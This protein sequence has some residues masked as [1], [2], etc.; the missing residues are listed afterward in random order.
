MFKFIFT[1]NIMIIQKWITFGV[2]GLIAICG[3]AKAQDHRY[4]PPWNT[5][6]QS[7]VQFTVPGIDNVPDLFGDINDPQLVV[8]FAG[9]QF[10]CID[11]LLDAFKKQYPQYQRVFAETLPGYFS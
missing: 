8:F 5:P 3:Q 7:K 2:T 4:D 6:P 10:M 1:H 11:E 9:N